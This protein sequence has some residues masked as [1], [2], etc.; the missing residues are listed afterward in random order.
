MRLFFKRYL[1]IFPSVHFILICSVS[2][3]SRK[4]TAF[5]AL[6]AKQCPFKATHVK[7]MASWIKCQSC[8]CLDFFLLHKSRSLFSSIA[9]CFFGFSSLPLLAH[10]DKHPLS[11]RGFKNDPVWSCPFLCLFIF[12]TYDRGREAGTE[13]VWPRNQEAMTLNNWRLWGREVHNVRRRRSY[14]LPCRSNIHSADGLSD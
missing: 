6:I 7:L 14:I 2:M 1:W 10:L 9:G 4:F 12:Y 11:N 5:R 13:V 3:D 8:H